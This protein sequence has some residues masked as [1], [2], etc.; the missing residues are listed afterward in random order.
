MNL[1]ADRINN[2]DLMNPFAYDWKDIEIAY[3]SMEAAIDPD[4][5][6]PLYSGGLGILSGD[7]IMSAADLGIPMVA[8][9]PCYSGGFFNQSFNE[10]GFQCESIVDWNP[11]D[12]FKRLNKKVNVR[13]G[14]SDVTVSAWQYDVKSVDG[15]NAVPVILLDTNLDENDLYGSI[16]SR[17]YGC[18]PDG[19][20]SEREYR[21]AQ[22][23]VLG[24][25]GIRMLEALGFT[26]IK[27]YHMNEGHSALMV[28]ELLNNNKDKEEELRERGLTLQDYLKS[29]CIFT[30]HTP[31][32]AGHDQFDRELVERLI[33]GDETLPRD[34]INYNYDKLNT[35]RLGMDYSGFINAVSKIHKYVSREMFPE[36][37][38]HSITNGVHSYRWTSDSFRK[39]YDKYFE[40]LPGDW[41]TGTL[42][43]KDPC[44]RIPDEEIWAAHNTEKKNLI[45]YAND[46]IPEAELNYNAFTIGFA[47]R[48]AQ[49][50]R[51]N[52]LFYDINKLCDIAKDVGPIQLVFAGKAHPKDDGGK[53]II[54][55]IK[56]NLSVIS[57]DIQGVYI[58]NYN[59][60]IA[61]KMTSGSDLWLNTPFIYKEA[62]GTSYMKTDG[63][64][65]ATTADGGAREGI[66]NGVNG[67]IIGPYNPESLDWDVRWDEDANALFSLLKN[68]IMPKYY[69]KDRSPMELPKEYIHIMKN[70][71]NL[72]LTDFSSGKMMD[73]YDIRAYRDPL[74][75]S[76]Y[77]KKEFAWQF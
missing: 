5:L 74:R 27:K 43:M 55:N 29:K 69:N 7:T 17:L 44:S 19:Y 76:D 54:Q 8:V 36:Y 47:R 24:I 67:F 46:T 33:Y 77:I 22:E 52:L 53:C 60:Q 51:S 50:K 63:V 65:C 26:N 21:L 4:G 48:A 2:Q 58:P 28:L 35:T 72:N 45:D 42:R 18:K 11:K 61:K 9:I 66:I 75:A 31:V 1:T 32:P 57:D 12:Y 10:E 71:A 73:E 34:A 40:T 62:C 70:T 37:N 68:V 30:T 16:T 3:F 49:Y 15:R 41:K 6:L 39:L 13:V 64:P 25:G 23:I 56:D 20:G 38:I 59:I 14:D